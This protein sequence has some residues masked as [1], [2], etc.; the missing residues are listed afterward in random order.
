MTHPARYSIA[1]AV[2]AFL[3]MSAA[4]HAATLTPQEEKLVAAAKQEGA[5]TFLNPVFADETSEAIG[6]A[7]IARYDLGPDFKFNNLRKGTGQTVAQLRQEI[8]AGKFT[9]DILMVSAPGFFDEAA[10]RGAFEALDSGYWKDSEELVKKAGQYSDYPY[11]VVPMAYTFQPVW[12]A[13]CPGMDKITINSYADTVQPALKEKT[14][15]SDITKSFTYTNTVVGMM[16]AKAVDFDRFWD[17]LKATDPIVEFRTEAKM[18][19]VVSCQ[20]PFDMWNVGGRVFQNV[21]KEPKLATALKMG[22]YKEGQVMLGNQAAVV[23][24]GPHP[25]AGKLFIEFLLSKEGADIFV[26]GEGVYT[27]RKDYTPPAAVKPYLLDL[28]EEKLVGLN[29]WVG[30]QK[31]FKDVHDAW[32]KRFK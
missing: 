23:K 24:G 9:V 25:N 27:F 6:K 13:S 17:E 18:Q 32:E 1:V 3:V 5:V 15:A 31:E 11:V 26:E 21:L 14:I 20:R 8:K 30:A 2:A 28:S 22:H 10:R 19:M 7:F 4:A 16:E 29:D 12:N